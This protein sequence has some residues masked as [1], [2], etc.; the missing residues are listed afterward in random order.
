MSRHSSDP[1]KFGPG[2]YETYRLEAR[3]LR[4]E[5]RDQALQHVIDC[6]DSYR[7]ELARDSDGHGSQ[8]ARR[9]DALIQAIHEAHDACKT[10][11]ITDEGIEDA[12]KM[13]RAV[14]LGREELSKT[15]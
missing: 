11:A 6:V 10:G 5:L 15:R 13:L 14:R 2:E 4:G 1:P 7:A 3:T 8:L 12:R 9:K